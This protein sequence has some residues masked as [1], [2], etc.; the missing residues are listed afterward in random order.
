MRTGLVMSGSADAGA[1][2][3]TPEPSQPVPETLNAIVSR[4]AAPFAS[5][6]AWRSDPAPESFV[7]VTV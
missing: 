6:R 7:F 1:I 4:P 3:Q 2:V 5:S